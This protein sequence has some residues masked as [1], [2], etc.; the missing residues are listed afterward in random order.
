MRFPKQELDIGQYRR[1][2]NNLFNDGDCH[3]FIDTNIISQLYKLNDAARSDFFNWVSTV[4]DRFHVP[5]WTVHEYQKKYCS[6]NTKEYLSELDNKFLVNSLANLSNFARGYVSDSL[7]VGIADYQGQKE[8]LFNELDDMAA[9]FK[10]INTA[11]NKNLQTHLQKVHNDIAQNLQSYVIDT[12]IYGIIENLYFD[13]ELRYSHLLPPGFE[14]CSKD[15]NKF[16]DLVIWKEIL[17]YCRRNNIKKV[18]WLTRD[19]KPDMAYTPQKQT[20]GGY[21]IHDN[22]ITIAHESLVYEFFKKTE[23]EDFYLINFLTFVNSVCSAYQ[24][25]ALSFQIVSAPLEVTEENASLVA[26]ND[27]DEELSQINEQETQRTAGEGDNQNLPAVIYSNDALADAGYEDKCPDPTVRIMIEGLASHNWYKQNDAAKLLMKWKPTTDSSIEGRDM[28]F[29]LGRNIY[30]GADG[31][32]ND[33]IRFVQNLKNYVNDWGN[34]EKKS[35][36]DGMLFEV[37]YNSKGEIR[38]REFKTKYFSFI[39]RQIDGMDLDDPYHFINTKLEYSRN[40]RFTPEVHTNKRYAFEFYYDEV[41]LGEAK[42]KSL[43]ING[44]D[45]SET[46]KHS[47]AFSFATKESLRDRLSLYYAIPKE[48][49][50]IKELGNNI[51]GITVISDNKL[52][53]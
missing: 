36:I 17:D 10:K 27:I 49:I 45:A 5:N 23:S 4:H 1:I 40:E 38:P 22:L 18:I 12:D 3:I 34:T 41:Q 7:L 14:D 47:L 50:D 42:T 26:N 28:L 33:C 31:T 25:L 11:I 2:I 29:V 52:S 21:P 19:G 39:L 15:K 16:G 51:N 20:I 53:L 35:F 9:K 37:F 6:K 43:I 30:Q 44:I 24:E 46:F 48:Q 8:K 13:G 32:S